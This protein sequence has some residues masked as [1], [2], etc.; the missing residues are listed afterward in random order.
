MLAC[1]YVDKLYTTGLCRGQIQPL[2]C[3]LLDD[4]AISTNVMYD[5][6]DLQLEAFLQGCGV[7]QEYNGW[8]RASNSVLIRSPVH[9]GKV[10]Y[11]NNKIKP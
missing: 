9:E 10:M 2:R 4:M 11:N 5:I 7:T 8:W 1:F 3:Q 6:N